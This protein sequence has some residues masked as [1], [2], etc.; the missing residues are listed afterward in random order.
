MTWINARKGYFVLPSHLS[1]FLSLLSRRAG[2]CD[3]CSLKNLGNH[4]GT[5]FEPKF[6]RDLQGQLG[7]IVRLVHERLPNAKLAYVSSRTYGGWAQRPG[8]ERKA[9]TRFHANITWEP[10]FRLAHCSFEVFHLTGL[11]ADGPR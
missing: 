4:A 3:G 6:T 10:A 8:A 11:C 9:R 7:N 2:S 1:A 5:Y